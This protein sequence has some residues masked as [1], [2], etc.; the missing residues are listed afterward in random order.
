MTIPLSAP[1]PDKGIFCY[2]K[3]ALQG[4]IIDLPAVAVPV[5]AGGLSGIFLKG[6]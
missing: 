5:F 6:L 1:E 2:H 3:V 4:L